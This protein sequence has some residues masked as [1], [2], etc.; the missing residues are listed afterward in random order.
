[1]YVIFFFKITSQKWCFHFSKMLKDHAVI[2]LT[3]RCCVCVQFFSSGNPLQ[4]TEAFL[5]GSNFRRDRIFAR[6]LFFGLY[7]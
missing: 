3:F 7:G 6:Q 4:Y 2:K 1:M 5:K